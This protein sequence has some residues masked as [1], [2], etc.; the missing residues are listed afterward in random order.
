[1]KIWDKIQLAVL[2]VFSLLCLITLTRGIPHNH[3]PELAF[4]CLVLLLSFEEVDTAYLSVHI[5]RKSIFRV[6]R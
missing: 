4:I 1:M 5:A 2:S 6:V 3:R